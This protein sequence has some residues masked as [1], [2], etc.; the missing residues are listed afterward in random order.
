VDLQIGIES[1]VDVSVPRAMFGGPETLRVDPLAHQSAN[2]ERLPSVVSPTSDSL[3]DAECAWRRRELGEEAM[4]R[5][6]RIRFAVI[7]AVAV[8]AGLSPAAAG[9]TRITDMHVR[10]SVVNTNNS[11]VPCSS[12]GLPYELDGHVVG[13]ASSLGASGSATLYLH[14]GS[15]DDIWHFDAGAGFGYADYVEEQARLGHTSVIYDNLGFGQ[16]D[17]PNGNDV[18][19][20]SWADMA[21]QV[22][23]ALHSGDYVTEGR[24]SLSFSHVAL[25]GISGGGRIAQVTAYSFPEGIEALVVAG[26]A[27]Q[28]DTNA[29]N[30]PQAKWGPA[31]QFG[32]ACSSGGEA[33]EGGGSGGGYAY[34]YGPD[35]AP[36]LFYNADPDVVALGCCRA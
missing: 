26:W 19:D 12:D 33:K 3:C 25:A 13:P 36:V 20:G 35:T 2:N 15:V 11:K 1:G 22:I 18:C 4:N 27:D 5:Q 34:L 30:D 21:S 6:G 16:S 7:V 9:P 23:A 10:F 29:L 32:L 14:G 24:S 17:I 28:V 31:V 8:I